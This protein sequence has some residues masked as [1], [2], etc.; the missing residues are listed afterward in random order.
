MT[1]APRAR[2]DVAVETITDDAIHWHGN[3]Q[4]GFLQAVFVVRVYN[5]V[6]L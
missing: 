6:A 1:R 3:I 4:H 2:L 5:A